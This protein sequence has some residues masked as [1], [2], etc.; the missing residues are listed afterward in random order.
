[1]RGPSIAGKPFKEVSPR[2]RPTSRLV[3]LALEK[4]VAFPPLSSLPPPPK[5]KHIFHNSSFQTTHAA[6]V[7]VG[8]H[9]HSSRRKRNILMRCLSPSIPA[10]RANRVPPPAPAPSRLWRGSL[11][12]LGKTDRTAAARTPLPRGTAPGTRYSAHDKNKTRG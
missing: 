7:E 8:T 10:S 11:P 12:A 1:M 5:N 4:V 9:M 3:N 6:A 2:G